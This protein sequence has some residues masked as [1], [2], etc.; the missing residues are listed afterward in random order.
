MS[1]AYDTSII[2][3][4]SSRRVLPQRDG[5]RFEEQRTL[6][7][8]RL[9]AADVLVDQP[10]RHRVLVHHVVEE[11]AART[12]VVEAPRVAGRVEVGLEL[13]LGAA[14]D[15][16]D[17]HDGRLADGARPDERRAFSSGG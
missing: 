1:G 13:R 12:L 3:S 16:L 7:H 17:A 4:R 6:A 2:P 8:D 10:Q 15:R 5:R 9:H 14:D 11:V